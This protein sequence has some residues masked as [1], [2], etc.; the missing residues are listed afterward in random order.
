MKKILSLI[1]V[2]LLLIP[3]VTWIFDLEYGLPVD[4]IGL[5]PPRMY[6]RA[7]LDNEY[8]NAF[9]QYYNDSFALRSPLVFAK[10]WIDFHIFS[11]TDA[12]DVHVGN[13]GWLYSRRS[14][15][16]VRKEAC[17]NQAAAAQIALK[18]YALDK[19]IEASGRRF[20]F[21]VAPNKSTIYPEFVGY[22]PR[23]NACN[24]SRY[25]L[26]LDAIA[27]L[28][29][30]NFVRFDQLL[31]EA[32]SSHALL[33]D[34]TGACWNGLGA[35]VAAETIQRQILEDPQEELVL[36]YRP[37]ATVD[38]GD[39]TR[40]LMGAKS[41]AG[42]KPVR[43]Y[44]GTGRPG[45]PFG[46]V[47]GDNF[48]QPLL[49]YLQ[50]MFNR[51]DV[52]R[53]DRVP[54]RQYGEDL[55]KYEF[56]LLEKA[57]SGLDS[58]DI[59]IDSL[60]SRF[61][62]Q[63]RI[64]AKYPF[65]LQAAEAVSDISLGLGVSG[66]QIKSVGD[67]SVFEL[68]SLPASDENIFRL[69]KLS[70]EAPHTDIMTISYMAVHPYNMPNFLK[71][72]MNAIYLPLPI[73][74]P[75]SIQIQPGNRPGVFSLRSA[76]IFE[77]SNNPDDE[78]HHPQWLIVAETDLEEELPLLNSESESDLEPQLS[79]SEPPTM[80]II[81]DSKKAG[82][83]NDSGSL[84]SEDDERS[85]DSNFSALEGDQKNGSTGLQ[86]G[87][88]TDSS[89]AK[90]VAD[91]SLVAPDKEVE[92]T[93]TE[94]ILSMD[95]NP[96]LSKTVSIA[97]TDFE[98]G[99]IFQ[100]NGRSADIV[101]SGIYTG[102]PGAI[103]ARVVRDLT[104]DEVVTWTAVDAAPQ[105]GIYVGV[106]PDVPQGGWYNLQVRSAE[107]R[108]VMNNGTHKWGVG[109][110]VACLGQSNMKEWFYTGTD[111]RSHSLL[112][113]FNGNSWSKLGRQGN[114]AIA[115]GNLIVE[116]RGIPVGFL[117]F[118]VNG[119]GLRK[120][121]DW[122]TGY[123]EDTARGSIYSHFVDGASKAG[124]AVEFVIWI[125]GEADAARGT[126]TEEEYRTSL[127][128]FITS[129]VRVDIEN[130]S[131]RKHL[132]FLVVG[133]VKRPGGKDDPH[134]AVRNAQYR[135][136]EK[137]PDCYLA[138]TTLDLKNQGRQHLSARA[139]LKMGYRVAQT[140]LFILG[141]ETYH[142]GPA[143][144][145][146]KQIDPRTIDVRIEHRGGTDFT[147]VS[148]MTGWEVL[149]ND[150]SVA[151][152]KVFRHDPQTIRIILERPLAQKT[153]IRYLY[154]AMPDA[155]HPAVDNSAMSLP[156]EEGQSEVN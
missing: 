128:G 64:A 26:L 54:S 136:V 34:K 91:L 94:Q 18:L 145:G 84:I 97:V 127:E 22:V 126:V 119:S 14:I 115:F 123:W 2:G 28:P 17:R 44:A 90:I 134:Q 9:D 150:T 50:Q 80:S 131:H 15:E 69:L 87:S 146:A 56:I 63:V 138:A 129:Q 89:L 53:A 4:R 93:N 27:T 41:P 48:L 81:A 92:E 130:G 59:D 117:D 104:D 76:E 65:D 137:V 113:K 8:Y 122:G 144:A 107:N 47:Y 38:S 116:R 24:R 10:R 100:R 99:R 74:K 120:E 46:I 79:S 142:R 39:L 139:Y 55:R 111:L 16:D 40:Q 121:A 156:L 31:S 3:A 6:T 140:V 98:D 118:S 114:A 152:T 112:Q 52:I 20:F 85:D 95:K 32:K 108:E 58:L 30:K 125:Q 133:M 153:M 155:T 73:Q 37:N 109:I 5:K 148:A 103:E 82:N 147:P 29:L 71:K 110:L 141:E 151:L 124:G 60:L 102:K 62:N 42:D 21:M 132:P 49:P 149:A 78:E 83:D 45:H 36:D 13:G 70:I 25:D 33:Y 106:I 105:N 101:V 61:E 19:V 88:M 135:V 1:F 77:F 57:E 86:A 154:G 68:K 12:P 96:S 75:L 72:G 7:L 35:M 51:L 23:R 11:M 67:P 43:H 66:L 143:I